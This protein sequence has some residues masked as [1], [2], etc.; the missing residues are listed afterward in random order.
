MA[1]EVTDCASVEQLSQVVRFVDNE[2]QIR[3]EFV[4]FLRITGDSL[5]KAILGWLSSWG[6]D[7][8]NCRGQGYDGASNMSSSR[9]GVQG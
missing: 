9:A 2:M 6:I 5:S 7:I 3:E 8:A 4:D 1:D